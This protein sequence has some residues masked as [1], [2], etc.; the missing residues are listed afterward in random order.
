ML[1]MRT[2]VRKKP[3]RSQPRRLCERFLHLALWAVAQIVIVIDAARTAARVT[4]VALQFGI[5]SRH[6]V[7]PIGGP[8]RGV[9]PRTVLVFRAVLIF[10]MLRLSECKG[11]G[12]CKCNCCRNHGFLH[13][14]ALSLFLPR[15]KNRFAIP[16]MP[17]NSI[18]ERSA[19]TSGRSRGEADR[20]RAAD[21]IERLRRRVAIL[22]FFIVGAECAALH[23]RRAGTASTVLALRLR[24][25][26][27]GRVTR[28][29]LKNK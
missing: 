12:K 28:F 24:N 29:A 11:A 18:S 19:C 26:N 21:L 6:A 3:P 13:S 5:V 22:N 4:V 7:F 20:A 14:G 15:T 17:L 27:R 23:F 9:H 10:W 2:I 16:G 8:S 1:L 25:V